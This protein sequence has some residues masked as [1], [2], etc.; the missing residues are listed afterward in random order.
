MALKA[1]ENMA[2]CVIEELKKRNMEGYYCEDR[3]AAADLVCSMVEKGAAVS[4]GGSETIKELGV[5]E[6]LKEDGCEMIEYPEKEKKEIGSPI[7]AKVAS[8]DYFLMST[9]AITRTGELVNIDGAS[10]RLSSLLHGPKHV[11]IVAGMNKLVKTVEDG[12]NRIQTSVCPV[13]AERSGRKTPCG[14]KGVCTDCQSPDCMCCN[15]VISR[16]SRYNGRVKVILVG[17]NLG[18]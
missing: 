1:Y 4:W 9:N 15:I 13:T 8:A 10:N 16:R 18:V 14:I 7:F 5:L 11:I 2:A 12:F 17:E 3:K 6:R